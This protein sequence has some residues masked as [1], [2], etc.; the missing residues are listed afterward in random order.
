MGYRID[1][2]AGWNARFLPFLEIGLGLHE[3]RYKFQ[4]RM[5][6]QNRLSINDHWSINRNLEIN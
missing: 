3:R 4:E 1:F 6:K 2:L 5:E